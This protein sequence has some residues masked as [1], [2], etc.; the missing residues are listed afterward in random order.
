MIPFCSMTG[1]N[2]G[3]IKKYKKVINKIKEPLAQTNEG[4]RNNDKHLIITLSIIIVPLR[5]K[6]G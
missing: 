1:N 4:H 2:S 3:V 6:S 5:V